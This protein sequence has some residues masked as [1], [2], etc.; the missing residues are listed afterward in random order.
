[1]IIKY[2][3]KD[4]IKSKN[5]WYYGNGFYHFVWEYYND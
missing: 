3:L 4:I 2:T 5:E 1:M